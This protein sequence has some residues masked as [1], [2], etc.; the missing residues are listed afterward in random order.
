[1]P[2][3]ERS[4]REGANSLNSASVTAAHGTFLSA[5]SAEELCPSE[6]ESQILGEL[7][8]WHQSSSNTRWVLGQP[9][10]S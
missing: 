10:P 4:S 5:P 2:K 3:A 1:M 7:F 9:L 8:E 6:R